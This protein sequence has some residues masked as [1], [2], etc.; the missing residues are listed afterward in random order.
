MRYRGFGRA[1]RKIILF[2]L[3]CVFLAAVTAVLLI[4][5]KIQPAVYEL[6]A[7]EAKNVAAERINKAVESVLSVSG[8]GYDEIAGISYDGSSSITGISVDIIKLNLL[9]TR[10]TQAVNKAFEDMPETTVRVPV[11]TAVSLPFFSGQGPYKTVEV[12]YS[13]CVDSDFGNVFESTGLNQ[14]QHSIILELNVTVVMLL[15]GK[16]ITEEVNTSFC[17]A[18]TVIVGSVPRISDSD[19]II[20]NGK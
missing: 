15:P 18:Q 13:A 4:E 5:A 6:A 20:T 9:K 17:V 7:L 10:V 19:S 11:G 2:R 12:G 14:T 8:T 16:K 3:L 1:N